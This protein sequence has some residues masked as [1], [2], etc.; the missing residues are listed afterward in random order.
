MDSEQALEQ[1]SELP[2]WRLSGASGGASPC[3]AVPC[4][5]SPTSSVTLCWP[6]G[7]TSITLDAPGLLTPQHLPGLPPRC[8]PGNGRESSPH[9]HLRA[10]SCCAGMSRGEAPYVIAS[11]LLFFVNLAL[12]RDGQNPIVDSDVDVLGPYAGH[13]DPNYKVSVLFE[14]RPHKGAHST[15]VCAPLLPGR[16][17]RPPNISSAGS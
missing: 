8:R 6:P 15:V 7:G 12:A 2:R 5:L 10:R 17:P 1:A 4:V 3:S 16:R 13:L 9:L 14:A 11:P